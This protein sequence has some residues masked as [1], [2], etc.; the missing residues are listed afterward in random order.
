M[1]ETSQPPQHRI[2]RAAE[3]SDAASVARVHVCSWQSAYRELLSQALLD[4][5]SVAQR[6][7]SWRDA[8][9]AGAPGLAT[10]VAEHEGRV[11]GFC[12]VLTPARGAGAAEHTC[13]VA[14]L[15]VHPDHWRVGI[16]R[17]LL[18]TA[19]TKARSSGCHEATV[20]VFAANARAVAFYERFGFAADGAEDRHE[21]TGQREVRLRA[22]LRG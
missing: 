21:P 13:E 15:Y 17:A 9:R 4:S 10:Y 14:A 5:L 8:L 7:T 12:T 3:L 22:P 2:V 1:A 20:W 11:T 18:D 6:E 19:L 16:G